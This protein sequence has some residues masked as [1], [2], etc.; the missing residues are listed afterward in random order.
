MTNANINAT[1]SSNEQMIRPLAA[2]E[3]EAVNGGFGFGDLWSGVE[4][5]ASTVATTVVNHPIA[6]LALVAGAATGVGA[7]ADVVAVAGTELGTAAMAYEGTTT[8]DLVVGAIART[9]ASTFSGMAVGGMGDGI[10][11]IAKMA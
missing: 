5:V 1:V 6:T 11:H 10:Y 4:S 8:T 9:G 2:Y 3:L 7:V